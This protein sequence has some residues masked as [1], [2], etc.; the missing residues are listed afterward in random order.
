MSRFVVIP[1]QIY[2]EAVETA[3]Q[4]SKL[5][6]KSVK[7]STGGWLVSFDGTSTQLSDEL[8]ISEGKVI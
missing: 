5:D 4:H 6:S 1:E 3:I 2:A 8:G 7:L